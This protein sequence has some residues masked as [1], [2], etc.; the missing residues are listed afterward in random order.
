M[1]STSTFFVFILW[2]ATCT[3]VYFTLNVFATRDYPVFVEN[4]RRP[5]LSDDEVISKA[6]RYAKEVKHNEWWIG[7]KKPFLVFEANHEYDI[8]PAFYAINNIR[9]VARKGKK[10][11]LIKAVGTLIN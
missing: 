5:N 4:Y 1:K 11:G 6:L 8:H 3:G 2:I 7:D 10:A 9:V